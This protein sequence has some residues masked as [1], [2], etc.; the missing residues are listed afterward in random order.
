M[1]VKECVKEFYLLSIIFEQSEEGDE[2]ITL[3]NNDLKY[4]IQDDFNMVR[5]LSIT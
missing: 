2:V 1:S 3:Y 5:I 4:A